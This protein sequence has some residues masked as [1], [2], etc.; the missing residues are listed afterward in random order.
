MEE[1]ISFCC[2]WYDAPFLFLLVDYFGS[3]FARLS[4]APPGLDGPMILEIVVFDANHPNHT[5]D[6]NSSQTVVDTTDAAC[7]K[8]LPWK[9]QI[10][11]LLMCVVAV[12]DWKQKKN[13][14]MVCEKWFTDDRAVCN[15]LK[16]DDA[17]NNNNCIAFEEY[18][19]TGTSWEVK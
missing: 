14:T 6:D 7:K 2:Y 3:T 1:D 18:R 8:L 13:R 11:S 10:V 12:L 9:L 17:N 15:I 19:P 4:L 16:R 5:L